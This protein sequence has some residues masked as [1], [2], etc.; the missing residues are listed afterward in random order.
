LKK[1]AYKLFRRR[2]DG[3]IGSL[4]I[5]ARARYE[6]GKWMKAESYRTKG[7]AYRPGWHCCPEM[8]APHLSTKGRVWCE[9]LIKDYQEMDRPASQGGT[10]YLA[11]NL[12]I[13]KVIEGHDQ[14]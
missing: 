9:V 5:N 13:T 4:F 7:Y 6:L 8:R 1:K 2:K 14:E 10:W 11:E 12:K 3:S